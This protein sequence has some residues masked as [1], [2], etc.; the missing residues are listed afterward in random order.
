MK[1]LT[2]D[3]AERLFI[4]MVNGQHDLSMNEIEDMT[5]GALQYASMFY[6]KVQEAA[7]KSDAPVVRRMRG[8]K[9]CYGSGGKSASPCRQCGGTGKVAV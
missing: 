9:A 5:M 6:S 2:T 7:E 3:L 8:C 1:S 4:D